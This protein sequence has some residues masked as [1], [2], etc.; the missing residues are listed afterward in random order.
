MQYW[1]SITRRRTPLAARTCGILLAI[2]DKLALAVGHAL[3]YESADRLAAVD[4]LTGLPNRRALFQRL[5]ADLARC[6]RGHG[7]LAV[8]VCE[9]DPL[10]HSACTRRSPRTCEV[11]AARAIRVARLVKALSWRLGAS[12][13]AICPKSGTPS[14]PCWRNWHHPIRRSRG[15]AQRTTPTTATTPKTCWLAR[16]YGSTGRTHPRL[17]LRIDRFPL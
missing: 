8:L 6:R 4:T 5:D 2:R 13:R 7:K 16:I 11:C 12:P 17:K 3:E 15:S 10:P 14:S 9:I 1:L